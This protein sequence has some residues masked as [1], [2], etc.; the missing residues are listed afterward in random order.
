M[1][2]VLAVEVGRK[3]MPMTAVS[4]DLAHRMKAVLFK[5]QKEEEFFPTNDERSRGF[6]SVA[7]SVLPVIQQR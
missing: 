7:A 2:S 1:I 6:H 4:N 5:F 3:T